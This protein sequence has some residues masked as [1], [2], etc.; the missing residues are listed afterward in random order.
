[1]PEQDCNWDDAWGTIP[2]SSDNVTVDKNGYTLTINIDA[3]CNNFTLS[4]G[5]V[6][7]PAGKSLNIGGDL[8]ISGR[9]TTL[10]VDGT[11][12]I[13]NVSNST[14]YPR[15]TGTGTIIIEN[16]SLNCNLDGFS[17]TLIID[18]MDRQLCGNF[19]LITTNYTATSSIPGGTYTNL[20]IEGT[21]T[22]ELCGDVI[23]TGS[24]TWDSNN[25]IRM[26]DHSFTIESSAI[27]TSAVPFGSSHGFSFE[28]QT[29]HGF[30]T[31]K[32]DVSRL[33]GGTI[34]IGVVNTNYRP[35]T[36]DASTT[37]A[38]SF[39]VRPTNGV[40]AK[41]I[42]TD[43]QCYWTTVSENISDAQLT[44]EHLPADEPTGSP[45]LQPFCNSGSG[46]KKWDD[47][48]YTKADKTITFNHCTP[49][50]KWSACEDI[51]TYY[52]FTSGNWEDA[53]SWTFDPAGIDRTGA[54]IPTTGPSEGSR[55]VIKNPDIITVT[56][57]GIFLKSLTINDGG[58]LD[59]RETTGHNLGTVKGQGTL[60][61]ASAEFPG[62]TYT[63]FVRSGGGTVEFCNENSFTM[64]KRGSSGT[65][66]YNN[67]ILNLADNA[68]AILDEDNLKTNGNLTISKGTFQIGTNGEAD[69]EGST[70]TICGD[71]TVSRNGS[72]TT[73]SSTVGSKGS[74]ANYNFY[75]RANNG[76]YN[77]T[78]ITP[79]GHKLELQGNF[80]NNGEV[81]FTQRNATINYSATPSN[82]TNVFF[83][84]TTGDQNVGINDITKFHTIRVQKGIDKTHVLNIDA[85]ALNQFFLLGPRTGWHYNGASHAT[86]DYFL[87]L[88]IEAGTVRLGQNIVINGLMQGNNYGY[89]IDETACLWID[90][91]TVT[92]DAGDC[93]AL[94]VHGDL[95]VTNGK[96]DATT[97]Q[98]IVYRTTANITLDD[99]EIKSN[100]LRT[101]KATG[102]HV[103]SLTINGGSLI[104]TGNDPGKDN[105]PT[106][107]LTYPD[108][109]F[110]MHGGE[111]II[112]KGTSRGN[113]NHFAL[114][115][116]TNIDNCSI[117]GGTVKLLCKNWGG[118]N[119]EFYINSTAP[120]WNLEI[121]AEA[122]ANRVQVKA[123]TKPNNE[124]GCANVAVQPLVV[125][126]DLTI[127]NNGTL[128]AN[129]E[130]V[131][132]G[133]N[134]TIENTGTYTPGNNTTY[135]NGSAV[136]NFTIGGTVTNGLNNL[137]LAENAQLSLQNDALMRGTLT[138][139]QGSVFYDQQHTLTVRGNIVSNSG[140]HYNSASSTGC[141]LLDGN[142]N[143]TIGGDGHGSF[144]NLHI[145]KNGG[146]VTATADM[147]VTGNLRLL[148]DYN[149]NIGTY[150]L[151]LCDADAAIYS[152]ATTGINDFSASRMIQTAGHSS[153]GGIT[154]LF[155]TTDNYLFPFGFDGNYLPANI[156]VDV[157]PT[158]YGSV[159]SRPVNGK[160]YVFGDADVLKCYWHNTSSG[161]DGVTSVNHTYKYEQTFVGTA[162]ATY[163]P[164]YYKAGMW[165]YNDNTSLVFQNDDRFEWESCSAIDG[166]F[167]CG[168]LNAFTQTPIRLYS[169]GDGLWNNSTTW[170]D[171]F[172]NPGVPYLNTIVIIGDDHKITAQNNA[173][174]GSLTIAED[175]TLDL[176]TNENQSHNLGVLT[177]NDDGDVMGT[178][179]I[180]TTNKFPDGDFGEFLSTGGGTI[181]YNASERDIT[182]PTTVSTYNNLTLVASNDHAVTMPDAD[183]EIFGNLTSKNGNDTH[184]NKFCKGNTTRTV[185]IDGDLTV[186]SGILAFNSD[187]VR[188]GN[189]PRY[190]Y[191][192][193]PQNVVVKG[194][195]NISTN[196]LL[197]VKASQNYDREAGVFANQIT[198]YGNMVSDGAITFTKDNV[199][200][201]VATT[202]T[203][204]ANDTI[205][206]AGEITL[207]TLTCDKG[208]DAT[209]VLSIERNIKATPQDGVFLNLLNGT[210]RADGDVNIEITTNHNFEIRS[211]ACLSTKSGIFRVCNT[212][213][214]Q[215]NVVLH[216][217]IEVL[218][219]SMLIGNGNYG[220][221]IE[222]SS[223]QAQIDVQGGLLSVGGQIRRPYTMTP[224]NLHYSQS[225][226]DVIIF[227]KNRD[228]NASMHRAVIDI[229]NEGSFTMSGG[230]LTIAGG[231]LNDANQADI[232]L[233]PATSSAT[234]GVLAIGNTTT[235]SNQTFYMSASAELGNV[236]VGTDASPQTLKLVTNHVDINGSLKINNGSVFDAN[237]YNANI[238][239]D[240]E[241]RTNAG[242]AAGTE[243]QLVTFDGTAVQ[244]ITG[245]GNDINFTKLTIS[246]PTT[247]QLSNITANC[248]GLLTISRGA[249]DDAGNHINA[250]ASVLND[251]RHISS[252]AGGGLFFVG[253]GIH[254]M[255]SSSGKSGTYGNLIIDNQ[256]DMENPI[257]V[258]GLITLNDD[259]YANDYRLSLMTDASF[260]EASTGM[261]ILNGAI[262]D[263]GVRKYFANGFSGEFLYRIGIPGQ[264]TPVKYNFTSAVTSA[265]GYINIRLM[266]NLHANRTQ[267]PTTYLS[268]YWAASSEGL[269]DYAVTHEYYYTDDLLTLGAG[270]AETGMV[271]QR[272][273]DAVWEHYSTE[274]SVDADEN[275]FVIAGIDVVDG[276]FTA[277]FPAYSQLPPYFSRVENGRWV[278]ASSWFYYENGQDVTATLPPSGNPLT[279]CSGH[280][281]TIDGNE[282]QCA[283][284]VDIQ[285]GATLD[286]GST[287][288]HNFGIVMGG[289]TLKLGEISG[290]GVYSF[291]VPA[292]KYDDFFS[293]ATSTIEF[294][295][296]NSA[297][298][299]AKPGNYDNPFP[300]IRLSGGGTKNITASALYVRGN[301][302]IENGNKLNNSTYNRDFYLGGDFIDLN[303][304]NCGY[305]C[306]TS[307]V[308]F[309]GTR[310]QK[311]DINVDANFYNVQ[312]DNAQGVDVTNG[313]TANKNVVV[314]N[315][316]TLTN[317][318]FLTNSDALIY[319]TNTNQNVVSGGGANSFVDGPLTKKISSGGSFNFPVGNGD[320]YGNVKLTNVNTTDNWTAQYFNNNPKVAINS[321]A[322][323]DS[324]TIKNISENEYWVVTRP[325]GGKAKVG[326][327][328][329]DQSCDMF[330]TYPLIQQRLKIVEYDGSSMWNVRE[331]T[332]SGN[333]T[334]G[335][336]TTNAT[337]EED[338]YIFT[339]G[340]AGVIAAITTTNLQQICN[341]GVSTATID[342]SLSGSAPFT[343]TYSVNGSSRTQPNIGTSPYQIVLNSSQLGST[344]GTYDVV[345]ESVSDASGI[346]TV[347]PSKGQIEV[348]TTYTPTF[349][350]GGGVDVAGTGETRTYEVES[351]NNESSFMWRWEGDG[352]TIDNPSANPISVTYDSN[353][354]AAKTYYLV[355]TETTTATGCAISNTLAITVSRT[356]QPSFIYEPYVCEDESKTYTT[357]NNGGHH[358]T[359]TVDGQQ[360]GTD[361]SLE[362]DWSEYSAGDHIVKVEERNGTG[363][364]PPTGEYQKT[365]TVFAKPNSAEILP[366]DPICSGTAT[367]V[368]LGPTE[369]NVT[370]K[371]YRR[372]NKT[373]LNTFS[374]HDGENRHFTTP[375]ITAVG[376]IEFY[377]VATNPGCSVLIPE[378]TPPSSTDTSF[379]TLVVN[380]TP[381]VTLNWPI[382]YAGV[383]SEVTLNDVVG[384]PLTTYRVNYT[385]GGTNESGNVSDGI[386]VTAT[387]DIAG[388]IT[389][390][391]EYCSVDIPFNETM[392]DGYVWSG[393]ASP[394]WGDADN[395]FSGA[396]P[397][398]EH[399]AIIRHS[400]NNEP[401]IWA[402]AEAKSVKIESGVLTINDDK[403]LDVYGNWQNDVGDEGFVGNSSTVA[404]KN[405]AE[406]SG[407]TTFNTISAESGN[408]LTINNNGYVTVN[409][410]VEN[411]GTLIG[412]EG[413]TL[414]MAGSS[415][416]KLVGGTYNLA[417]LK[418]NKT[419]D[420]VTVNTELKVDGEFA[421]YGGVLN[422]D[423]NMLT[424]GSNATTSFDNDNTTA[425]VDG[426]MTK[427]GTE[428]IVFPIG[429]NGR[430]AMVGIEPGV[431]NASTKFTA[432]YTYVP[433]DPNAAPTTPDPMDARMVRVSKM[434]NWQIT[435]SNGS[436]AK[437]TLYWDDGSISEITK[438]ESLT[439]AHWNGSQWEMLASD[440]HGS[441]DKGYIQTTT[442][443]TS[444]SPFT[445]GSTEVEDNPL[446]IELVDFTGRQTDN[447]IE[448]EWTTQS[449]SNNDYFEIER[450]TDGVNFVTIGFIQGAGNSD[451]PLNYQ[452][453][454]GEP[455]SGYAYY[456]LSQVD[457]DGTR[458][459]A[460]KVIAIYYSSNE[461][462]NLTVAPN[463]TNGL[464]R[465]SASGS[466]AGG[467][468][469]L[470]SQAG[471]VI[472]IVN[473]DDYDAT[474]DISDLPDGIYILRFRTSS[475]ILQQKVVKY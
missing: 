192:A 437:V 259:I 52:S 122:A 274:G 117:T 355:V 30:V 132:V 466:M 409:G 378:V 357:A 333:V 105:F 262:G 156:A 462:D 228:Q 2:T 211:S 400:E 226:G 292:G 72:I 189:R 275:K 28:S 362:I 290:G 289:G 167:T 144:N 110:N 19:N 57:G 299:P 272:Y 349:T 428:P 183:I 389:I 155:S 313:G 455:V 252:E 425:Y 90:G 146:T 32:G 293:T 203:G 342:V 35:V 84:K 356:P 184:Y 232:L 181:E 353:N 436:S 234:G 408:T 407:S 185:T 295:G 337:V 214:Q 9:N 282:P 287:I 298:L 363:R 397:T 469:E 134:F 341:D 351:H 102:T 196:A 180:R 336:L 372:G 296:S 21:G 423:G 317:G 338:N 16:G 256:T 236:E 219:G 198:I 380:E 63:T 269:S 206:G 459:Y 439:I 224:V 126:N 330:N 75:A 164:A 270:D 45:D 29:T 318:N 251:S 394:E 44:F 80:T 446:P 103:G 109:G 254:K 475:Q 182:I 281:I 3:E 137:T 316:L 329:D 73:G 229:C 74:T 143:Q 392:A 31:I 454:D 381:N 447:S 212:N 187:V 10:N 87:A 271:P 460:D 244:K 431:A 193:R 50:G 175:A 452:F 467:I 22:V 449:E 417:N 123:F 91:A 379:V 98:G 474:I 388:T 85:S 93:F 147:A 60:K 255:M 94:Y 375:T 273:Y 4:N 150:N 97:N 121:E 334:S 239:G 215:Y 47:G 442:A 40:S 1:M 202:F 148:S 151:N 300:N 173:F 367:T 411:A 139:E 376:N 24:L 210:F 359:W 140:T 41:G 6:T 288:G 135:F 301:I 261:I 172:G 297:V 191:S 403:T 27:I 294:N 133:G 119:S 429:N 242:F 396:I 360:K 339:F 284:S 383:E 347:R 463:P 450:S 71:L 393:A 358:Y 168:V 243:E 332:A 207:Y 5:A 197:D 42:E 92:V 100:M 382:L 406:I 25:R 53:T 59:L 250:Y 136:Q 23:V 418:I 276:E 335:M 64:P 328:W 48:S 125:L 365:I 373:A 178:I 278:D 412:S 404:F 15:I 371:L 56:A 170:V 343:L 323:F 377:A 157:E 427:I 171:D 280:T 89:K 82:V 95:K 279:I 36:I 200:Q 473:V 308:I 195:V 237:G 55:V 364:R 161:F 96:L 177:K 352:P 395:W 33:N 456:R 413:S 432:G 130:N 223:A 129:D 470:L 216:G 199:N 68:I 472:R 204:T 444:F 79:K 345:L 152:N 138:L 115:L 461:I 264:Y 218:G 387:G 433:K 368:T 314:A 14:T 160:H 384:A 186:E 265:D 7:V 209:P 257:S 391:N 205:K 266:N 303:S 118:T 348:L 310:M 324:L 374:G 13:H 69:I 260:A 319:L 107:G 305:I 268:Y 420:T 366:I 158:T 369:S 238:A 169:V 131:Y 434:D 235:A 350:D 385:P 277:G 120:F 106:F 471:R 246:N 101:S 190:T 306:G 165:Y 225:G 99:G 415:N 458:S 398:S 361:Y 108:G 145:S 312:I 291:M 346:G 286:A 176:G 153:D 227:G 86:S 46:W 111:L 453:T 424:L 124:D 49:S 440:A 263:A 104:F 113:A 249:F 116:G 8:S 26:R 66:I 311:I 445:F 213:N 414:E 54:N 127:K 422:M 258:T 141:I 340:F 435:G 241:C 240:L 194:N 426:T 327:R 370:Y 142:G 18:N 402:S 248:N 230:T 344:T 128:V 61:L 78:T 267:M 12:T 76:S 83:T 179:I 162:E 51:T 451:Q 386:K 174:C 325:T 114:V 465:I 421:I 20:T 302:T 149:L 464:F 331:A 245:N 401:E 11:I 326:L 231:S 159:T 221:D 67:L 438:L 315:N 320:R 441:P 457:Y 39:S 201:K 43:L 70:I 154:R 253:D 112:E 37:A 405:N 166:D 163:V 410:D 390:N 443:V 88:A 220:N 448:L 222:Y 354:N 247:V 416:T 65:T 17:G 38:S 321:T 304:E 62:G 81:Y 307:N 283:Y 399:D 217:K 77:L 58:V 208:T 188:T 419:S 468:I 233:A 34:P 285:T 309:V 430:R 322:G